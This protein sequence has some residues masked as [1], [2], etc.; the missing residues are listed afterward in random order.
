M[1]QAE[2][3]KILWAIFIAEGACKASV[4]FGYLPLRDRW[5]K[6]EIGFGEVMAAVIAELRKE[7]R[8]WR[9]AV[10]TQKFDSDF[11]R[12][13]ARV[14]YNANT[15]EWDAWERNVRHWLMRIGKITR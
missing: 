15:K 13:L 5:K 1:Q 9:K 14:G 12:W 3:L 7:W 4:P 10:E 2:L 8:K 6:K 11:V